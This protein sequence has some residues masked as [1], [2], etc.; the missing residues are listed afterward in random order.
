MS[1]YQALDVVDFGDAVSNNVI[2][3]SNLL[4]ELGYNTKIYTRWIHDKRIEY[5]NDINKLKVNNDDILFYHYSG[6]SSIIEQIK[7]LKCKKILVYHN[8]TPPHYF[9][10]NK[11]LHEL[12]EGGLTQLKENLI[13]FDGYVS[14]SEFNKQ[15]LISMGIKEESIEVIP[16]FIDFGKMEEVGNN[17][18]LIDNYKN[19]NQRNFLFVGRIVP[20]KKVEDVLSIFNYYYT[21]ISNNSNLFLVGNFEQYPE[22]YEELKIFMKDFACTQKVFFTG[23]VSD[24]DLYSYYRLADLFLCMSEHEGF[25]VPLIESMYYNIP[26]ISYDACAVKYTM[27][28][29]GVLVYK[30]EYDTIGELCNLI[31]E[32]GELNSYIIEK[33]SKRLKEFERDSIIQKLLTTIKKYTE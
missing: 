6:K 17:N 4:A 16:I 23:K 32:D 3:M 1:I 29:A 22:Y 26:I 5:Y 11:D 27:G 9:K 18:V 12:C 14:D 2:N 20:N 30:K 33:Q 8:I 15:D 21:K 25:C 13:Y 31:L 7:R 24:S 28:D 10:N 19:N